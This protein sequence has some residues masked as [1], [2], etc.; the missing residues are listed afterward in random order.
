M[1]R[2]RY[3]VGGGALVI[4][5]L[6]NYARHLCRKDDLVLTESQRRHDAFRS[7]ADP[8]GLRNRTPNGRL[9][10]RSGVNDQSAKGAS[11]S[12]YLPRRGRHV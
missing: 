12:A 9:T 2:D 8:S 10:S 7:F 6:L 4:R 5:A 1:C 3:G 11:A